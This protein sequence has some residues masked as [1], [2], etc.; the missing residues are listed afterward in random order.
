MVAAY[1]VELNGLPSSDFKTKSRGEIIVAA[2]FVAGVVCLIEGTQP[3]SRLGT[4]T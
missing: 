3:A 4:W 1:A 2:Q